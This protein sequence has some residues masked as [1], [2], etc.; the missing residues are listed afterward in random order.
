MAVQRPK[1]YREGRFTLFVVLLQV[2]TRN[3][4]K[5]AL[6]WQG[7]ALLLPG[8]NSNKQGRWTER[9]RSSARCLLLGAREVPFEGF[10]LKVLPSSSFQMNSRRR[11]DTH[12]RGPTTS[13]PSSCSFACVVRRRLSKLY[14]CRFG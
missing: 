10:A 13:G 7:R 4:L 6:L 1:H 9:K 12:R 2:K 5:I 3:G 11:T 14:N 8:L